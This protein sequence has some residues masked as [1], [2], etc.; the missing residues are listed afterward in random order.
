MHAGSQALVIM[1]PG[2]LTA[3]WDLADKGPGMGIVAIYLSVSS[4]P[5]GEARRHG[6]FSLFGFYTKL[7]SIFVY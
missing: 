2:L 3:A 6:T 1:D 5:P 4:L 7:G